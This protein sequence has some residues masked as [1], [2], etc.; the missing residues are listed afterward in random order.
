[1]MRG[2]FRNLLYS[3]SLTPALLVIYGNLH[4]GF[5][6]WLNTLYL[7]GF[8]AVLEWLMP[9]AKSN[10]HTLKTDVLPKFILLVH[11]PLQLA[12][13]FSF[14]KGIQ[15]GLLTDNAAL[16]AAISMG[17]NTGSSAIV[18]AHEFIHQKNK[19]A[20]FLGRWL[21]FTAGN[22]QFFVE[23]LRVHHKWVGTPT[24][25][26]SAKKNQSLYSFFFTSTS[27]QFFSAFRLENQRMKKEGRYAFSLHHYVIRQLVLHVLFDTVLV[28]TLGWAALGWFV[29]HCVFANFLL[30]YVNYIEHYGLTRDAK[31]RTTELH[32]WQSN[33]PI[34]RFFLI[35]LSRHADHHY[36]ASKPYHNLISYDNSP[37]LPSGYAGMFLVAAIPPLWFKVMNKRIPV[38]A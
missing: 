25:S 29:L 27:G 15:T 2:N 33:Q 9:L 14:F 17:L 3:L 10:K 23:H 7:L 12:C 1:M 11:V 8:L 30:E 16:G 24:D 21:L 34:S 36:Y 22:F 6:V 37:E 19:V 38:A 20:Q 28:T 5:F 35:D 31:Q 4:G 32:S 18:V 13:L 26:A